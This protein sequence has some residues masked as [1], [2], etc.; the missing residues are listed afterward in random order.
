MV[1]KPRS[2]RILCLALFAALAVSQS[3][4]AQNITVQATPL[5]RFITQNAT[6]GLYLTPDFNGGASLN[7]RYHPFIGQADIVPLVA[8][9]QPRADQNLRPVHAWKVDQRPRIYYYYSIYVFPH[10]S[11]YTYLG[12]I[13]YALPKFDPRGI[14]FHYWYSQSF[15][16]YYTVNGENPPCCSFA[17]HDTSWNLPVGGSFIF[18]PIP[19]PEN[20]CGPDADQQRFECELN[21]Q[22]RWDEPSCSCVPRFECPFCPLPEQ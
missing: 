17:Y 6:L 11:D 21:R 5:H 1:K 16:Y 12:I 20:P 2:M 10:G 14:P 18:E 3:V 7:Y 15:G 4:L 22:M 9:Y 8:G 13:G 19:G